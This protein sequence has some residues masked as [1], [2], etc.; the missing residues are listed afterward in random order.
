[1]TKRDLVVRIAAE[2]GLVQQDVYAVLQKTLDHIT[3]SMVEGRNV[4]FRDFGVF[5]VR[6]RKARKGYN[7]SQPGNYIDI[8]A[9]RVVK[10]KPGKKMRERVHHDPAEGDTPAVDES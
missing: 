8:P 2:T 6:S 9:R 7:P 4:E 5:D 3:D 10:F 1:L